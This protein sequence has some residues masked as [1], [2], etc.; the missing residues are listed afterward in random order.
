MLK[1][2]IVSKKTI[3]RGK[4]I[5]F[6]A[7]SVLIGSTSF[8]CFAQDRGGFPAPP[9]GWPKSDNPAPAPP[10]AT[11]GAGAM[12][13][14]APGQQP[15]DIVA[16]EQE[17][18]GEQVIAKGNVKVTSK[19]TVITAP[20]ATLFR[21]PA[22]QPQLAIFTG[23]PHLVQESNKIDADKLTFEIATGIIH[24]DGNAHSEVLAAD[25]DAGA[26]A[27]GAKPA[28]APATKAAPATVAVKPAAKKPAGDWD[29]DDET[30]NNGAPPSTAAPTGLASSGPAAA[31]A[32]PPEKI[33]TDSDNQIY[34]QNTGHFEATGHVKVNHGDIKVDANHL[35]LVYGTDGKPE[36]A[37]FKG[38]V[39]ATQNGNNTKADAMTY[40]LSTQR[41][42]ATGNVRSKVIQQK[43]ATP[44]ASP[45]KGGPNDVSKKPLA[46]SG[47]SDL[48]SGTKLAA[49]LQNPLQNPL[50][51]LLLGPR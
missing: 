42:Q 49:K 43:A 26:P 39:S 3:T 46:S 33:Y 7:S 6:L 21:D 10:G 9:G 41:L 44:E 35:Q 47:K 31:K 50:Q 20:L 38:A 1:S 23:H 14:A 34:E 11:S 28:A 13:A 25:A 5:L 8:V 24:A 15:I 19:G 29:T 30:N 18:A 48:K 4:V 27:A 40:Y 17:F 36:T 45:K 2:D 22:G 37:L 51:L 12:P 16:D 32:K